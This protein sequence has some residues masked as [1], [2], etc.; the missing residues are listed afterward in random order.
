MTHVERTYWN[1]ALE[2]YK[3]KEWVDKPTIF[4]EQIKDYLPETGK[5]LELAAGQGQDSRYFVR[6][7][8]DVTATDLVDVGLNEAKRKAEKEELKINFQTVDLSQP[9][10]FADDSFEIVYSHLGLHYLDKIG[11][12]K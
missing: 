2:R 8:Y 12:R 9:L 5:L 6:Q 11:Q 1:A 4:A 7:G 3:T 10:P